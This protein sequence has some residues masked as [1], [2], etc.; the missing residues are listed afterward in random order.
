MTEL[1]EK[2]CLVTRIGSIE[3]GFMGVIVEKYNRLVREKGKEE[4][5]MEEVKKTTGGLANKFLEKI[6]TAKP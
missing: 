5:R 6:R 4:K 3:R 1:L 2:I